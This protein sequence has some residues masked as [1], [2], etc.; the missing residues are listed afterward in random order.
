MNFFFFSH[1]QEA[2]FLQA[3]KC[4]RKEMDLQS[5]GNPRVRHE[6][7]TRRAGDG[8]MPTPP[9]RPVL[10]TL[11]RSEDKEVKHVEGTEP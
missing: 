5:S 2:G 7:S 10:R 9:W 11:R 8:R 4:E 6:G 3:E 1:L